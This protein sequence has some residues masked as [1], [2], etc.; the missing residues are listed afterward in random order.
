LIKKGPENKVPGGVGARPTGEKKNN[1]K[2]PMDAKRHITK[3]KL[4]TRLLGTFQ[5]RE[6]VDQKR[7]E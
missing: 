7:G 3:K 4:R 1:T 5:G 6:R 2:T